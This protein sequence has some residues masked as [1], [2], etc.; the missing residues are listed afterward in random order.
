MVVPEASAGSPPDGGW[1]R[2]AHVPGLWTTAA[3]G[4]PRQPG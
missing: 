2:L 4:C 3:A 1:G